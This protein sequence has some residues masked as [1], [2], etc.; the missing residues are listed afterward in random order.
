VAD[1]DSRASR[2]AHAAD[3]AVTRDDFAA[4]PSRVG[5]ATVTRRPG[6]DGVAYVGRLLHSALGDL[7][8]RA[9]WTVDLDAERAG[10]LTRTERA[11]FAARIAVG[12]LTQRFDLLLYNHPGIAAAHRLVPAPLRTP[13]GVFVH[14]IEVWGRA[15]S[16]SQTQTL[17]EAAI[18]LSNSEYTARRVMLESPRAGPV[19]ACRLALLPHVA[20][21]TDPVDD[22]L[23]NRVGARSVLIAGRMSAAERYKGHDQLLDVW[24]EVRRRVPTAQLVVVGGGDDAERLAAK[25]R[26]LGLAADAVV[27]GGRVSDGTLAALFSR[28]RAFAMPSR[29]EGFGLVYLQ[30]MRAGKPC[31]GSSDDAAGDII[32]HGET[33]FLVAQRDAGATIEALETL[34][35][36]DA[37]AE[38]LG[39]AG[40]A[41]FEREFTYE[42]FVD[43]LGAALRAPDRRVAEAA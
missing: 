23:L 7:A 36:N 37:L 14:G 34:L 20:A 30:A 27:F 33:G 15:M 2:G 39:G 21:S 9:P 6:A 19:L 18:V 32:V 43:R 22:A 11:R 29:G 13:Y 31:L 17:R 41:R 5:L 35:T 26:D 4:P 16:E 1:A 12:Q 42:R 10:L 40:R 25:A 8:G 28:T 24:P 3:G 38:R